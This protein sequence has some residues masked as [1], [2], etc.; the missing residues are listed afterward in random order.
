MPPPPPCSSPS[1]VRAL[2]SS[3]FSCSPTRSSFCFSV[4]HSS[5]PPPSPWCTGV[6]ILQEACFGMCRLQRRWGE[7]LTCFKK[8]RLRTHRSMINDRAVPKSPGCYWE[9]LDKIPSICLLPAQALENTVWRSYQQC[10]KHPPP[11]VPGLGQKLPSQGIKSRG[12]SPRCQ[13][14]MKV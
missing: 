9:S 11:P 6:G 7:P 1:T 3:P 5:L 4:S 13:E 14:R 8:E 2:P 10:N 12:N